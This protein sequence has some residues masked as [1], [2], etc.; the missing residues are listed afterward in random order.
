[1]KD[2]NFFEPFVEPKKSSGGDDKKIVITVAA[3]AA[4][5]A[6]IAVPAYQQVNTLI[7]KNKI[8]GYE[9]FLNEDGSRKKISE[10]ERKEKLASSLRAQ[11]AKVEKINDE[12]N[13]QD[14]IGGHI[15][16]TI[17]E[18]LAE[19]VFINKLSIERSGISIDGI[20]KEKEGVAKFQNNLR[21]ASY[22]EEVFVPN[23]SVENDYNN[24]TVDMTLKGEGESDEKAD[25]EGEN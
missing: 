6:V 1:L 24:F 8:A 13:K 9:S 10:L 23:I 15:V 20:S 14:Q 7:M 12:L 22:F 21:K 2:F 17:S 4:A 16:E 5:I 3:I 18:S 11:S 19:D 25:E